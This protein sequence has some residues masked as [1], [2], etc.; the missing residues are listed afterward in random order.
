MTSIVSPGKIDEDLLAPHMALAHRRAHAPPPGLVVLAE[1]RIAKAKGMGRAIFFPKQGPRDPRPTKFP[2]N[3]RPIRH[4]TL[5]IRHRGDGWKQ[6]QFKVVVGQ[7]RRQRPT[8]AGLARPPEIRPDRALAERK[9]GRNLP[10]AQPMGVLQSHHVAYPAHRQS[11]R[12]HLGPFVQ[13]KGTL[14]SDCRSHR[15]VH[16][17][18]ERPPIIPWI[19][20]PRSHG[21]CRAPSRLQ[22]GRH[23]G[24]LRWSASSVLS[25]R[26]SPFV[27][28]SCDS[29]VSGKPVM[30]LGRGG[31]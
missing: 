12:W 30:R 26:R 17:Y 1:P 14:A 13:T 31:A 10:F 16:D 15:I 19:Q 3:R 5:M 11:F 22:A 7:C 18:V 29:P 24:H 9:R 20:R 8:Q 23:E 6:E 28:P 21:T 4:G 27:Y 2:I 25:C